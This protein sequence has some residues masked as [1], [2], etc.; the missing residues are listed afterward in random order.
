[1][2]ERLDVMWERWEGHGIERLRLAIGPDGVHAEG[3]LLTPENARAHYRIRCDGGWRTHHVEVTVLATP[4]RVLRLEP[5][6][7]AW[8]PGA[9]D[10]DIF[11]SPFTNT[12]P[13]RRAGLAP[14]ESATITAAWVAIP[15]LTVT[16]AEQRYT[17]LAEDRYRFET[18]DFTTEFTV[19]EHGLV[20]DY[21]DL[22]RRLRPHEP[23]TGSP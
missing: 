6:D 20:L 10:V 12:L 21:P 23:G 11:P 9:L 3:D 17:R 7:A 8:P 2:S 1:M 14:G 13:I 22:A 5:S 4:P 19:D 18:G 15:E 16:P